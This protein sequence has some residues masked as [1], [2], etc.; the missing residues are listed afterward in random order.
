MAGTEV[1]DELPRG[2]V[3]L[4]EARIGGPVP[5]RLSEPRQPAGPA[6]EEVDAVVR[7]VKR[8]LFPAHGLVP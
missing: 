7:A 8:H 2:W 3:E 5:D 4:V 1:P 6:D